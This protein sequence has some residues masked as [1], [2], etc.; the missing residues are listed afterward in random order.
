[1]KTKERYLNTVMGRQADRAPVME[2]GCWSQTV[3]AWHEQGMPEHLDTGNMFKGNDYLKLEGIASVNFDALTP[4]PPFDS[5]LLEEDE[6]TRLFTDSFGRKRRGDKKGLSMDTY[7]DFP[8]KDRKSW[9]EL[10]KR[11]EGTVEKRLAQYDLTEL[12]RQASLEERP[13]TLLDPMSGTFG[14]YSML[15]N[16]IGTLELSYML[17]DEEKLI[18][19]I[20]DFLGDYF[21]EFI[22]EPIKHIKF[23]VYYIHED[24]CGK[25]GPLMGPEQFRKFIAPQYKKLIGYLKSN[26]VE[27]VIIDT[28]GDFRPLIPI[29]LECGVDGFAPIEIASGVDPLELRK[30]YG[31]AFAMSGA[32]DK[33]EIAKSRKDIDNVINNVVSPLLE[34]G[35]YIPTIDH[36]VPPHVSYDN[37]LYYLER[38]RAAIEKG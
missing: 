23:D 7:I 24:M 20:I 22:R 32:V 21:L 11:Y 9:L 6:E 26:G 14:F 38:K 31:N 27:F 18:Q 12:G 15:R 10:R 2:I 34:M 19:E 33:N 1:M 3:T 5:A 36:A 30:Q 35:R 4:C 8:V 29:F 16:L 37:F 28:D 17:Y 13:V 25:G